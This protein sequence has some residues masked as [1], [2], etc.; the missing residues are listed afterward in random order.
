MT[1][2][3]TIESLFGIIP[4]D[5][6]AAVLVVAAFTFINIKGASETGKVGTII[7][8]VQLVAILSIIIAG[9][10][11]MSSHP[12]N[13]QSNFTDFFPM[14]LGGCSCNGFNFYCI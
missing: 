9:L 6:L 2:I 12:N 14:G 8:I 13:W 10:W 11:A 4:L 7:T 3:L 1:N 5:K